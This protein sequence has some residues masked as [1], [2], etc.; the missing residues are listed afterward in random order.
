MQNLLIYKEKELPDLSIG[1]LLNPKQGISWTEKV[2]KGILPEMLKKYVFP[3]TAQ[4]KGVEKPEA[5]KELLD[6]GFV[7]NALGRKTILTLVKM[8]RKTFPGIIE[9]GVQ[10]IESRGEPPT[11]FRTQRRQVGE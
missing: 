2:S 10:T 7:G 6:L 5:Q 11:Q 1:C 8:E 3:W 9:I 4:L